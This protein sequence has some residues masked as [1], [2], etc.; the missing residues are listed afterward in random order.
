MSTKT[1][2]PKSP[3]VPSRTLEG[4]LDDVKKL[5]REYSHAKFT[6]SE[7]GSAFGVSAATGPF[8]QR[9]FSIKEFG[10]LEQ[11]GGDYSTQA[12]TATRGS[13]RQ[14]SKRFASPRF[15]ER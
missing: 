13:S 12:T 8:A 15:F 10:L 7:M 3:A 6:K 4:C 1:R 9:L 14:H 5:Y 11:S 2:K